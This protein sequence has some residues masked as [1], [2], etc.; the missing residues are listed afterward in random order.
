MDEARWERLLAGYGI[1]PDRAAFERLRDAHAEPHRTYHTGRHVERCLEHL[2]GYPGALE[3]R[4][5]V[6]VALWFHDAV[7]RPLS[8]TNEADS[9]ALATAFLGAHGVDP[10][11]VARVRGLV[12]ATAHDVEP[13][14]PEATVLVDVDLAILGA[15]EAEYAGYESAVRREYRLVPGPV[16]RRKRA[17]VLRGFLDRGFVYRDA[18]FRERLEDR[19]VRNLG[20]AIGN[21]VG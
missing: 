10:D 8:R 7:Y 18:H 1:G 4:R 17:A 13:A 9:A 5:D 12:L 16:Y 2:D 14:S 21:L 6:E 15:D 19:A 20:R 3:H 11:A